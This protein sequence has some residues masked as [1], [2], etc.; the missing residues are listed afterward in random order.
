MSIHISEL[1]AQ[2]ALGVAP[3][4]SQ[5]HASG[6]GEALE[7]AIAEHLTRNPGLSLVARD[8]ETIVG[9]VLCSKRGDRGCV[10]RLVVAE[11]H[12]DQPIAR[13]LVD[14]AM[15]K[16]AAQGI[17]KC[18][19]DVVDETSRQPFWEAARWAIHVDVPRQVL[20]EPLAD[21]VDEVSE[22]A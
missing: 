16:L 7:P 11:S 3:L 2:D 1:R 4:W 13:A 10:N 8:G 21:E 20:P 15:L 14:K 12:K 19:L 17:H 22:A 5:A 6:D 9:L 18:G